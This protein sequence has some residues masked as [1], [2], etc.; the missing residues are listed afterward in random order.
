MRLWP[1]S[2]SPYVTGVFRLVAIPAGVL[3][4]FMHAAQFGWRDTAPVNPVWVLIALVA[5]E[6][7]LL[8]FAARMRLLLRLFKMKIGWVAA[9]RIHFQSMFYY[10]AVPMTVG[11]EIS[12][13][14]KIQA[15]DPSASKPGL[16]AALLIDRCIGAL[17]ALALA[18]LC[19]PGLT[20][21]SALPV[22]PHWLW[23][24]LS[25]GFAAAFVMIALPALRRDAAE[26]SDQPASGASS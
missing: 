24:V 15:I 11:L 4:A 19:L 12:R 25:V 5:N 26:S 13:F 7:A 21:V 9:V 1:E 20:F 6:V 22:Q 14:M 8:I 18:L 10:V 3:W 16:A 2:L 23:I 17:A